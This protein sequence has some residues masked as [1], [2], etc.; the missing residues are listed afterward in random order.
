MVKKVGEKVMLTVSKETPEGWERIYRDDVYRTADPAGR[1]ATA[2]DAIADTVLGADSDGEPFPS[3]TLLLATVDGA[4]EVWYGVVRRSTPASVA[5][6]RDEAL[7]RKWLRKWL[8]KTEDSAA[9]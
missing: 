8:A 4:S 3:S 5:R 9:T 2:F 6:C 1:D 7:A